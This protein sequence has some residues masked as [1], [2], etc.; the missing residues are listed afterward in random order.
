VLGLNSGTADYSVAG[1][2]ASGETARS[3]L[4]DG[5]SVDVA[6]VFSQN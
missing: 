1:R 6:E 5:F 3:V 4:L 2:Y